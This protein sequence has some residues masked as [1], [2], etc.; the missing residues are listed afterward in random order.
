[1]CT[2]GGDAFSRVASRQPLLWAS[3]T[4]AAPRERKRGVRLS[5]CL[6]ILPA[7]L[8]LTLPPLIILT[9]CHTLLS[10]PGLQ[11]PIQRLNQCLGAAPSSDHKLGG[12]KQQDLFSHNF[13]DRGVTSRCWQ[14]CC[15]S[16]RVALCPAPCFWLWHPLASLAWGCITSVDTAVHRA[17][18]CVSS[19]QSNTSH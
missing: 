2:A 9:L 16:G 18:P 15:L 3:W 1:M 14:A 4:W 17:S 19:S 13:E 11:K 5:A 6:I 10:A 8:A 12:F 7:H